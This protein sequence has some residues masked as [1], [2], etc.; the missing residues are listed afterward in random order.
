LESNWCKNLENRRH[1]R[2]LQLFPKKVKRTRVHCFSVFS[3]PHEDLD[4]DEAPVCGFEL[5]EPDNDPLT[6][7]FLV[8]LRSQSKADRYSTATFGKRAT[9]SVHR[10]TFR[11]I[12]VSDDIGFI[13]SVRFTNTRWCFPWTM[14]TEM[15]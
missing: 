8:V 12:V 6:P 1:Y 2:K 13:Y 7:V 3:Y 5:L 11:N 14:D 15:K 9:A 10:L 4:D